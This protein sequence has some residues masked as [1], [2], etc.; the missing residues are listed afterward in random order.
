M[1]PALSLAIVAA[2]G[3][4]VLL[5]AD[6]VSGCLNAVARVCSEPR[7]PVAVARMGRLLGAVLVLSTV[8]KIGHAGAAT[9]PPIQRIERSEPAPSAPPARVDATVATSPVPTTHVVERGDCLWRIARS[10]LEAAGVGASGADISRF[11]R[12]IYAQNRDAIGPDPDLILPGQ[13]L[14]IPGGQHGA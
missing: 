9:P 4:A 3:F 7:R 1:E 6:L 12:A 13:V 2:G 10:H 5:V 8:L 11:W 14:T